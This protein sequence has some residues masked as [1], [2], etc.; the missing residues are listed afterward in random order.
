MASD[1]GP[2]MR[3]VVM[4]EHAL[5]IIKSDRGMSDLGG[6]W[7]DG[8]NQTSLGNPELYDGFVK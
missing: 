2:H 8:L 4:G 1:W 3:L 6:A 7:R 5:M